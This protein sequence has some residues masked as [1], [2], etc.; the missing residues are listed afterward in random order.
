[1]NPQQHCTRDTVRKTPNSA[2]PLRRSDGTRFCDPRSAAS[3]KASSTP[4]AFVGATGRE[5]L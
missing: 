2:W 1:M 4:A 5:G 3:T